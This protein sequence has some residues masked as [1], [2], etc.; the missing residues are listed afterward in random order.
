ML[1]AMTAQ[2]A[3]PLEAI[4]KVYVASL[5]NKSGAGE[6]RKE[7]SYE[8]RRSKVYEV[9]DAPEQA[10]ATISGDG[11][12]YVKSY[13]SLNPRSGDLPG[14]GQPKYGG[15]LSVEL[16]DKSGETLWSYLATASEGTRNG[17]R[18]L[19]KDVVKHLKSEEAK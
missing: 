1:V 4:K 5:G 10:D 15:S 12:V 9:V 18:D 13:I 3:K 11:E 2:T 7:L 16:K 19:A 6:L 17:A 14:H 8:L